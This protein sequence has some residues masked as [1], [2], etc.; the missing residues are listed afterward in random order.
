MN[1]VIRNALRDLAW[2]GLAGALGAAFAGVAGVWVMLALASLVLLFIHYIQLI[3]F[4]RWAQQLPLGSAV[5]PCVGGLWGLIY[6]SLRERR[7]D[8]ATQ[9]ALLET[10]LDRFRE[11]TDA[12]PEGVVILDG[13]M[14]IEWMNQ[15]A[16]TWLNLSLSSDFGLPITHFLREPSFTAYLKHERAGAPLHLYSQRC[17]GRDLELRV[18]PFAGGRR[19]MLVRDITRV[20]KLES[21]RRDF[22]ANVSHELR[23]PLTVIAGFIETLRD[24]D[25]PWSNTEAMTC[26]AL[27]DQQTRRMQTLLQDL[28][29]LAALETDLP[30]RDERIVVCDLLHRVGHEIEVLAGDAYPVSICID[31]SDQADLLIGSAQELYS[32]VSN[33]AT[34]AWRYSPQGGAIELSWQREA[35]GSGRLTVTDQGMGIAAEHLPRLTE[36]FYRVD[37]SRSR[38]SGGTGLGLAIVKHVLERHQGRLDIQSVPGEGSRFAAIF[39]PGRIARAQG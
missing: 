9:K 34:N 2:I 35:D 29:T 26:L 24:P 17:P 20:A 23:T 1:D 13:S 15:Q 38:D 7:R 31:S 30:P 5:I 27:M 4:L 11:A 19:V 32:V 10:A 25:K 16:Q 3:R 18:V 33:L 36:R 6:Q 37:R 39:A 14:G 28:L 8:I 22:V 12:M 21:M